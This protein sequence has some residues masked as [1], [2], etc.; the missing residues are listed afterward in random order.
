[1]KQHTNELLSNFIE[2][3]KS[4]WVSG[5]KRYA[6]EENKE[7]TDLV[8]EVAG[9]IWIGGNII[10]YAGEIYNAKRFN[11]P[12]PEVDFF[13]IT[14]YSFLWW[15]KEF[16][17][18]NTGVERKNKYWNKYL[19]GVTR[20]LDFMVSLFNDLN[21]SYQTFI[22]FVTAYRDGNFS[23]YHPDRVHF[24]IGLFGYFWWL[25][26]YGNFTD[27]DAGEE[28]IGGSKKGVNNG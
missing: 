26:E 21:I 6:L 28:F 8:C 19:L 23:I 1:M 13:K 22:D 3:C 5:G 14:V 15:L 20:E 2:A 9:N 12:I 16:K 24:R 27:E 4:Q 25:K 18:M 7:Y 17:S 11:E 10:K